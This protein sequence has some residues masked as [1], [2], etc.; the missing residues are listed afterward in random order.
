MSFKKES[1]MNLDHKWNILYDSYLE[2]KNQEPK[3]VCLYGEQIKPTKTVH[4]FSR[5]QAI[6]EAIELERECI[7]EYVKFEHNLPKIET[8]PMRCHF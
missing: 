2:M 3:M 1:A 7:D 8:T 4:V 6:R 5:N